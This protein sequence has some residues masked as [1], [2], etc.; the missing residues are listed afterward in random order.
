MRRCRAGDDDDGD[1]VDDLRCTVRLRDTGLAAGDTGL[2]LRG[3]TVDGLRLA[4]RATVTTVPVREK[5]GK[6]SR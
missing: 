2:L 6:A 1:G 5:P 3:S 4:G